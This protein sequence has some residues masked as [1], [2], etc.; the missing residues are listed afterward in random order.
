MGKQGGIFCQLTMF[1]MVRM[2]FS[3]SL[4]PWY[5]IIILS[6]TTMVSTCRSTLSERFTDLLVRSRS[7]SMSV[8]TTRK[9]PALVRWC[10]CWEALFSLFSDVSPSFSAS[11]FPR[12]STLHQGVSPATLS[13]IVKMAFLSKHASRNVLR[14]G[15]T[16]QSSRSVR[17]H[18]YFLAAVSSAAPTIA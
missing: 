8:S 12:G 3:T 9:R 17:D 6:A 1:I 11:E 7:S 15:D 18:L 2:Y 10:P 4:R 13:K 16:Y 5:P 14:N